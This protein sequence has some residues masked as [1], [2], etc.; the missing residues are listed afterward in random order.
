MT[1]KIEIKIS[2][3][4]GVGHALIID[5]RWSRVIR[6]FGYSYVE[7]DGKQYEIQVDVHK[8]LKENHETREAIKELEEGGGETFNSIEEFNKDLNDE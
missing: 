3:C 5:R 2:D 1:N 8:L 7:I 4:T 6:G